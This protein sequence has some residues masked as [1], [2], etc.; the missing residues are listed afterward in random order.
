LAD[1][2][3]GLTLAGKTQTQKY[4]LAIYCQQERFEILSAKSY[5]VA[6][7]FSEWIQHNERDRLLVVELHDRR[8]DR[9]F[10]V[11]SFHA[12]HLVASNYARRRQV[13]QALRILRAHCQDAPAVMAGDY[14][15][16]WF[17]WGLRRTV[18]RAGFEFVMSDKPTLKNRLFRGHFDLATTVNTRAAQASTLPLGHSDHAPILVTIS[19]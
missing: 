17:K 2:I 9:K 15:Y 1:A 6:R 5:P 18:Q 4:G 10:F 14:N 13:R 12:I 7:S 16:P 11:A 3:G 19:V 8:R